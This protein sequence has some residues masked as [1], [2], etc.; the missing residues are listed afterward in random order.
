MG[1]LSKKRR[2]GEEHDDSVGGKS[3]ADSS[4]SPNASL[5][6]SEGGISERALLRKLDFKLLPALTL[7]YLLSFLDR[8]NGTCLNVPGPSTA[9]WLVQWG[10]LE[11]KALSMTCTCVRQTGTHARGTF[12]DHFQLAIS[13]SPV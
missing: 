5:E 10:M 13:T 3:A 2:L 6:F 1:V 4:P 11:L 9:D 12:T 8:S 7:L